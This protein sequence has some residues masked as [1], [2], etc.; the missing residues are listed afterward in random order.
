MNISNSYATPPPQ[1][2]SQH[3]PVPQLSPGCV[4][5]A[6][7]QQH[8]I[9]SSRALNSVPMP[10]GF[11]TSAK[12]CVQEAG[13]WGGHRAYRA[14]RPPGLH[15][16]SGKPLSPAISLIHYLF[17]L[18]LR[19]R[20]RTENQ[21]NS[22]KVKPGGS[23]APSKIDTTIHGALTCE[24]KPCKHTARAIYALQCFFNLRCPNKVDWW[25]IWQK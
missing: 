22:L 4:R 6:G 15:R 17:I 10:Q 25:P 7:M 18:R 3:N 2:A 14:L 20:W 8:F 21:E 13:R 1:L 5:R 16:A 9:V 12:I 11:I 19:T 24:S 23:A